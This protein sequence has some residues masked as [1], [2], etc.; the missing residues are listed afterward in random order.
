MPYTPDVFIEGVTPPAVGPDELNK[1][2]VGIQTATALAETTA[3]L[4]ATAGGLTGLPAPSG[5]GGWLHDA[6]GGLVYSAPAVGD[7]TGLPAALDLV[8]QHKGLYANRPTTLGS[9]DAG[10]YYFA[11]DKN[12]GTAYLWN[13]VKWEPQGRA[14]G[15][16][17]IDPMDEPYNCK[18]DC[19]HLTDGAI[20][21]LTPG[22][23]NSALAGFT[24]ADAG[25]DVL[26]EWAGPGA[27]QTA[28]MTA[29]SNQLKLAWLRITITGATGGS[30]AAT[31]N[32]QTAS[33]LSPTITA[34]ALQTALAGLS[35]IGAGNVT[36][37]SP[38]AGVYY[39]S[40]LAGAS[41]QD[42][43]LFTVNSAGLTGAVNGA[44]PSILVLN[45]AWSYGDVGKKVQVPA[46]GVAGGILDGY[47]GSIE[48][49]NG[50]IAYIYT[51]PPNWYGP[52]GTALNATAG[53][54][55]T[56]HMLNWHRTTISTV[57]DSHNVN[58][59]APMD[60]GVIVNLV[61]LN[62]YYGTNDQ[63]GLDTA[64]LDSVT[65]NKLL[66]LGHHDY[67]CR[68][69]ITRLASGGSFNITGRDAN[70]I[71]IPTDNEAE[72]GGLTIGGGPG[73]DTQ[74]TRARRVYLDGFNI[75]VP[76]AHYR[77]ADPGV[78]AA[79]LGVTL[80]TA[81]RGLI[82]KAAENVCILRVNIDNAYSVNM[83]LQA[84]RYFMVGMCTVTNAWADS[85]NLNNSSTSIWSSPPFGD[86][87]FF[88]CFA[89]GG[90]DDHF[91]VNYRVA[92]AWGQR[93]RNLHWHNCHAMFA[94][95]Q[96]FGRGFLPQGSHMTM[97]GCSAMGFN[98]A[99]LGLLGRVGTNRSASATITTPGG[100]GALVAFPT[101]PPNVT[102][103][104]VSATTTTEFLLFNGT[105]GQTWIGDATAISP[106]GKTITLTARSDQPTIC[107]FTGVNYFCQWGLVSDPNRFGFGGL[108]HLNIDGLVIDTTG[109]NPIYDLPRS[110]SILVVP[111]E[112]STMS[113]THVRGRNIQMK[114]SYQSGI[115]FEQSGSP[116]ITDQLGQTDHL[117]SDIDLDVEIEGTGFSA[118]V[119]NKPW[120][121]V[122]ML[123]GRNITITGTISDTDHAAVYVDPVAH[124]GGMITLRL[125]AKDIGRSYDAGTPLVA[126]FDPSSAT[127][128]L[129][130]YDVKLTKT[131]PADPTKYIA[132]NVVGEVPSGSIQRGVWT[133]ILGQN[134]QV[135]A[136]PGRYR[137]IIPGI[138]YRSTGDPNG[139]VPAVVGAIC[140]RS[141]GVGSGALFVKG[142]GTGN[143]GWVSATGAPA[144]GDMGGPAVYR[145]RT[146]DAAGI[147]NSIATT[148]DDQ[149][150]YAIGPIGVWVVELRLVW[151]GTG[152]G[153][154]IKVILVGPTGATARWGAQ[155]QSNSAMVSWGTGL[156]GQTPVA[157]LQAIGLGI[158]AGSGN[159]NGFGTSHEG[160]V[161][162]DGIH[163]GNLLVRWGAVNAVA[164][165][166]TLLQDSWM[167]LTRIG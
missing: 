9:G 63:A 143:T 81:P 46:A 148:D 113:I 107:P 100:V 102:A 65:Q 155:G 16:D 7:V 160:I 166:I 126:A 30:W 133:D 94:R 144:A 47:I 58:L 11:E 130:D 53:G 120:P 40:F 129:L 6:S 110:G 3:S 167:K 28:T 34:A 44:V 147:T 165:T 73:N 1:M 104:A 158:S 152:T 61:G 25:K 29:G 2:G 103:G 127:G 85:F 112:S 36:V 50:N 125:A 42:P 89:F 111:G 156:V 99:G 159:V 72:S 55:Y 97:T 137:E 118:L 119:V 124:L 33:G 38:S 43:L 67:L 101:P 17:R 26:I 74:A 153:A 21:I 62:V 32:G 13:G 71:F 138:L 68:T 77:G 95:N 4:L 136:I 66:D 49:T 123:C 151:S 142:S 90:G 146:T 132:T 48:P 52:T 87:M 96:S 5:G 79:P 76:A 154:D 22:S 10:Y 19:V 24:A 23:L 37:T 163:A 162:C 15:M 78:N 105:T 134:R 106:D 139:V 83:N 93:P 60:S 56:Y 82:V 131:D 128:F 86:G 57:V 20:S 157:P 39:V 98:D 35:S 59:T 14:N 51:S 88:D 149:L 92:N 141:D 109:Q 161:H 108:D 18:A 64:I 75:R 116:L 8:A 145:Y 121:G 91:A 164:E 135:E 115:R 31:F 150:F 54:T 84:I 12:G 117:C 41:S 69:G 27:T 45:Q 122:N 114:N 140:E 80:K 70:L